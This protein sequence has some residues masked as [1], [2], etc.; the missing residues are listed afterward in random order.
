VQ[1]Y[2]FTENLRNAACLR[3][4][5]RLGL[6]WNIVIPQGAYASARTSACCCACWLVTH[7]HVL[8]APRLLACCAC[9]RAL[10]PAP[11]TATAAGSAHAAVA[12]AREK[13][14][15]GARPTACERK[16]GSTA[17]VLVLTPAACSTLGTKLGGA[18]ASG[19]ASV[20]C[21][22]ALALC[23]C[24]CTFDQGVLSHL[25]TNRPLRARPII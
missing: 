5:V 9:S 8:R 7:V 3:G 15:R 22:L 17:Y 24:A 16:D 2:P 25:G 10:C 1:I 4:S 21:C 12:P 13:H 18:G 6:V 11:V 14:V 23:M 20:G 19:S